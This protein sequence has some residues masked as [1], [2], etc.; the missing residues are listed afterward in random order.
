METKIW[1]AGSPSKGHGLSPCHFAFYCPPPPQPQAFFRKK[2]HGATLPPFPPSVPSRHDDLFPREAS[3]DTWFP[4]G[5]AIHC[6]RGE[7]CPPALTSC[8]RRFK[9]RRRSFKTR[10]HTLDWPPMIH[11]RRRRRHCPLFRTDSSTRRPS[12]RRASP[13]RLPLKRGS[14]QRLPFRSA[15]CLRPPFRRSRCRPAPFTT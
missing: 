10:C 8:C 7:P 9:A 4:A 11:A 13:Q 2:P 14:P 3:R 12:L 5:A 6:G 15:S 1:S